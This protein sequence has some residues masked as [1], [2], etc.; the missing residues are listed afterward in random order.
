MPQNNNFL[1][2]DNPIKLAWLFWLLFTCIICVMVIS[3]DHSRTVSLVYWLAG[4]SWL[5]QQPLYT[6]GYIYPPQ[7]AIFYIPLSILPF[8]LSEVIWRILSLGV[9]AYGLYQFSILT[10]AYDTSTQSKSLGFHFL[11]MTL[12]TLLVSFSSARNGQMHLLTTGIMML[13]VAEIPAQKW[14]K[15]AILMLLAFT[16]KPTALVLLLLIGAL[17]RPIAWR[18]IIGFII[19]L[20][21][22]FLTQSPHYVFSQYELFLK[23]LQVRHDAGVKEEFAQ[24]FGMLMQAGWVFSAEIQTLIRG[25]CAV[26]VLGLCY[27]IK[28]RASIIASAIWLFVLSMCYLML[29]NP[30][31]EGNDYI[32]LAPA[33]GFVM[34]Y[35]AS[36]KNYFL[37]GFL[38]FLLV[39]F[40]GSYYIAKALT[41]GHK[42]WIDPFIGCVFS[43]IVLVMVGRLLGEKN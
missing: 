3:S 5:F 32:M 17:Y 39:I 26:V 16:L 27:L 14:T 19:F 35:A 37:V 11:I 29:L 38:T 1:T 36:H 21:F 31:T 13:A 23:I 24:L 28:K 2:K 4:K 40:H 18:L 30:A 33:I 10:Q 25:I 9:F 6:G 20:I 8:S 15:V 43:V 22:P 41:P 42:V 34:C 12:V 7:S